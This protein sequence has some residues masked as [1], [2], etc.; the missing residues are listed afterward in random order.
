MPW[1]SYPWEWPSTHCTEAGCAPGLFLMGDKNLAST[2]I[3][4]LNGPACCE[5]LYWL[6]CPGPLRWHCVQHIYDLCGQEWIGEWRK[7]V[8]PHRSVQRLLPS[9][10]QHFILCSRQQTIKY[11][12][13]VHH[14]LCIT[15]HMAGK[16]HVN[17]SKCSSKT[18]EVKFSI[19]VFTHSVIRNNICYIR[20]QYKQFIS[21]L[22]KQNSK[23]VWQ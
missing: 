17:I 1:L 7:F 21:Y 11:L 18:N 20:R 8:K 6:R 2:G 12:I 15:V 3:W 14:I 16:T 19:S 10:E 13:A 4:R 9:L 22:F 23:F 5:S